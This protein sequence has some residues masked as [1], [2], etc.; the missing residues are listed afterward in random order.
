MTKEEEFKMMLGKELTD[1]GFT[2]IEDESGNYLCL[3]YHGVLVQ[4]FDPRIVTT[5]EIQRDAEAI[6]VRPDSYSQ[7]QPQE[8]PKEKTTGTVELSHTWFAAIANVHRRLGLL[9]DKQPVT[10]EELGTGT[11]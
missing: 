7:E 6:W 1:K 5:K 11:K 9:L 10:K 8:Q 2:L 4:A 3:H